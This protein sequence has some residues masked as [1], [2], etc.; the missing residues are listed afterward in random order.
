MPHGPETPPPPRRPNEGQSPPEK[1][2]F[3]LCEGLG[4]GGSGCHRPARY[5]ATWGDAENWAALQLCKGCLRDSLQRPEQAPGACWWPEQAPA[6]PTGRRGKHPSYRMEYIPGACWLARTSTGPAPGKTRQAPV[7]P[8]AKQ[9]GCLLVARASTH[10][11]ERNTARVLVG[12][13]CKH[14][15]K[16]PPCPRG[17]GR[18]LVGGA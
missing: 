8:N 10:L 17:N 18:V 13:P 3:P 7:L 9:P 14:P 4:A 5:E 16:H 15:C 6:R 1:R 2:P 11:T 12:S